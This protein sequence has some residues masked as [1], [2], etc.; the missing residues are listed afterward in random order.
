MK[1]FGL[2]IDFFT[3]IIATAIG[4]T[5]VLLI[6]SARAEEPGKFVLDWHAKRQLG[7]LIIGLFMIIILAQ[8]DYRLL[9]RIALPCYF[10]FLAFLFIVLLFGKDVGGS[11]RWLSLF[12][13]QFQPS[14]FAKIFVLLA[15]SD[16][17]SRNLPKVG[18]GL[19]IITSLFIIL[20]P[21]L[22]VILEPDLGTSLCFVPIL[23]G[24][25]IMGNVSMGGIVK[26]V[27]VGLA[28][29]PLGWFF[30]KDYQKERILSFLNPSSD[31]LGQ[32]YQSYQAKIAVGSGGMAG[33][34]F[35]SGTQNMLG[36][37]PG[38]HTDFIFTVLAEE[39]GFIGSII[40]LALFAA[41]FLRA[42]Q[43]A[44]RSNDSLARMIIGGVLGWLSFQVFINIGV[45]LGIMPVTGIP[46]PLVSYGGSS[47]LSS[48]V[49]VGLIL[50]VHNFSP[51]Y[52]RLG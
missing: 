13:F 15:L 1:R 47:L 37:I 18:E 51:K 4:L 36:L 25:M 3:F 7:L 39:K 42:V 31:V 29:M 19:S 44:Y 6:A 27:A 49:A 22:L 21:I 48:L 43:I 5:G 34:G 9:C 28:V 14:E 45:S 17:L 8:I 24:V 11:H 16:F 26:V 30:L 40:L 12:G 33:K 38:Q 35:F 10:T 2:R 23:L 41:L 52:G 20:P 46:L 32:G 50:S